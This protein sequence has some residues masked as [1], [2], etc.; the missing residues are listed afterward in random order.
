MPDSTPR[1]CGSFCFGEQPEHWSLRSSPSDP[2]V[3]P[4]LRSPVIALD[5]RSGEGIR[6]W[7]DLDYV[8]IT[9]SRPAL[10][11]HT[12][13]RP[14]YLV[15]SPKFQSGL[16]CIRERENIYTFKKFHWHIRNVVNWLRTEVWESR[17]PGSKPYCPLISSVTWNRLLILI[18]LQFPS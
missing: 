5:C 13:W 15:F 1:D 18:N 7:C 17:K 2:N 12:E 9:F 10:F 6:S 3:R 16:K 11:L 14:W 4:R 8:I